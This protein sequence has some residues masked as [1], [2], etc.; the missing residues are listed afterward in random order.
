VINE[1]DVIR[2]W[3]SLPPNYPCIPPIFEIESNQ[4]GS[5]T[6]AEADELFDKLMQIAMATIGRTMVYDLITYAQDYMQ[7]LIKKKKDHLLALST[8]TAETVTTETKQPVTAGNAYKGS[9][10][11]TDEHHK[12]EVMEQEHYHPR[13]F[14]GSL[15]DVICKMPPS[16]QIIRVCVH[17]YTVMCI[18]FL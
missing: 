4:S 9:G 5:F 17:V 14:V 10:M 13:M 15:A 1:D 3:F 8:V 2:I 6:F 16:V 12:E 11:Q 18:K 7:E